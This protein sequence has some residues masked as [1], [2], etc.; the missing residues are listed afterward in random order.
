MNP[1][2]DRSV[3]AS[4]V[5]SLTIGCALLMFS[6]ACAGPESQGAGATVTIQ[7]TTYLADISS[8]ETEAVLTVPLERALAQTPSL[9]GMRSVSAHG[10]STIWLELK[11][12]QEKT[13]LQWVQAQLAKMQPGLP[14]DVSGPV[15]VPSGNMA[16]DR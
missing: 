3:E 4:F 5:A 11:E 2:T 6:A 1:T 10:K 14:A 16:P 9:R 12:T 13:A 8:E 15:V 7:V